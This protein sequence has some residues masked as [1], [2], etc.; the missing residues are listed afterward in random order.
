M[1]QSNTLILYDDSDDQL[2]S[3][4]SIGHV[5]D[6]FMRGFHD[7]VKY[8]DLSRQFKEKLQVMHDEIDAIKGCIL[9]IM[10]SSF[11]MLILIICRRSPMVKKEIVVAQPLDVIVDK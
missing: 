5:L 2:I 4:D 6:F 8:S 11:I 7:D 1:S 9:V 3:V 10:L